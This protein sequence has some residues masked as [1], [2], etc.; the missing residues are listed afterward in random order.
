MLGKRFDVFM[1]FARGVK[2]REICDIHVVDLLKCERTGDLTDF[3]VSI[4]DRKRASRRFEKIYDILRS[5]SS[6]RPKCNHLAP[7]GTNAYETV[8]N[9]WVKNK[10]Q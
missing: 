3:S 9:R 4:Y 5:L 10:L 7:E 6:Q 2:N 1:Q 8:G